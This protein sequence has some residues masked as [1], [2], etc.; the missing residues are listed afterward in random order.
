MPLRCARICSLYLTLMSLILMA[1]GGCSGRTIPPAA[2]YKTQKFKERCWS[3]D[4]QA[5]LLGVMRNVVQIPMETRYR[6]DNYIQTFGCAYESV[7]I[8]E[9]SVLA[10]YR[11]IDQSLR[12]RKVTAR[13]NIM[14]ML[15]TRPP[16]PDN[17]ARDYVLYVNL[18]KDNQVEQARYEVKI[19]DLEVV[20]TFES[21]RAV[22]TRVITRFA[23]QEDFKKAPSPTDNPSEFVEVMAL[24]QDILKAAAKSDFEEAHRL[25]EQKEKPTFHPTQIDELVFGDYLTLFDERSPNGVEYSGVFIGKGLYFLKIPKQDAMVLKFGE[26]RLFG[27]RVDTSHFRRASSTFVNLQYHAPEAVLQCLLMRFGTKKPL[28]LPEVTTASP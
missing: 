24:A 8:E 14:G 23:Y 13:D 1:L 20:P 2:E 22:W 3:D 11:A 7:D 9:N 12:N 6:N 16:R 18:V 26:E 25:I 19:L 21:Q 4:G 17:L 27:L 5:T 28:F 15:R 10:V